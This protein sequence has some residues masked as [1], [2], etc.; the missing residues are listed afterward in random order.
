MFQMTRWNEL[1][2]FRMGEPLPWYIVLTTGRLAPVKRRASDAGPAARTLLVPATVTVP[3][4]AR[5]DYD[6]GHHY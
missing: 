1:W 5:N 3:S 4:D 2:A 6:R